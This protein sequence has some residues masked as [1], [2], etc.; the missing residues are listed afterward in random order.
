MKIYTQNIFKYSGIKYFGL[1]KS[2][3]S[4][5]ILKLISTTSKRN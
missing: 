4:S 2:P 5:E 3:M 1:S